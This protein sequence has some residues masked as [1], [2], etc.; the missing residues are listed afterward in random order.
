MTTKTAVSIEDGLLQEADQ[1][2]VQMGLSRS[3]LFALAISEF[4]KRERNDRMLQQLNEVYAEEMTTAEKR[5]LSQI[6]TKVRRVA[7]PK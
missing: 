2:A 5:L 7:D 1:A 4:L 6:K 3:R